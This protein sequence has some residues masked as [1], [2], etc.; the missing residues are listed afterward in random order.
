MTP[1]PPTRDRMEECIHVAGHQE[2]VVGHTD[3]DGDGDDLNSGA[4]VSKTSRS[5]KIV[6]SLDGITAA[7]SRFSRRLD[8]PLSAE[9]SVWCLPFCISRARSSSMLHRVICTSIVQEQ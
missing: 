6:D 2:N 3:E 1:E 4:A 8:A 7:Q 5:D 9:V